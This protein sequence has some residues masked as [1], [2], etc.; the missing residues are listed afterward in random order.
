MLFH[1]VFIHTS[2]FHWNLPSF[3]N[4]IKSQLK[5]PARG[6]ELALERVVKVVVYAKQQ[7]IIVTQTFSV[8]DIPTTEVTKRLAATTVLKQLNVR[9]SDIFPYFSSRS[10]I[11]IRKCSTLIYNLQA[12]PGSQKFRT[13]CFSPTPYTEYN[14]IQALDTYKIFNDTTGHGPQITSYF[15]LKYTNFP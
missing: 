11:F 2:F 13:W 6:E 4:R 8:A 3:L 1:H 14:V 7:I 12:L 15:S 9:Q 10:K 5:F